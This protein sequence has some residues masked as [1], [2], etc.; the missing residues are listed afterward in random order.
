MDG[1]VGKKSYQTQAFLQDGTRVPLTAISAMGNLVSQVKREDKE[2]YNSLQV[3][4][5]IKKKQNRAITGHSKKAGLEKMPRFFREI[6]TEAPMDME[7]GSQ[8]EPSSVFKPGDIIDVIGVTKGKG[9]AGVVK[10]HHF[11]GGP[12]THGQSDRERAPGS[13]GQTTTPGR[14]Y[15]GKRMAGRMG[16]Q[17]A[18]SK[19]LLVLDVTAD[20]VILV[21]GLIPGPKNN[22]VIV[23][24][25]GE[26]KKFVPIY[27]PSDS[28]GQE[29]EEQKVEAEVSVTESE[30]KEE[31]KTAVEEVQVPVEEVKT[32]ENVKTSEEVQTPAEV[33]PETKEEA[34]EEGEQN[35][36]D[37]S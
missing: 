30:V 24:K 1:L 21:K 13:I 18:T 23:K 20:G 29:K 10:R 8:I 36:K 4:F 27:N 25:I 34:K 9:F 26:S 17:Q 28:S 14:V 15:R 2:G 5:D 31:V 22:I 16:H 7:L 32:A 33:K 3:A 11:K 37:Q 19:N 12:R 35:A 6:R